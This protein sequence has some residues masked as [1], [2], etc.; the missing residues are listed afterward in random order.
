MVEHHKGKAVN[1]QQFV[2]CMEVI[3]G[4]SDNK[5]LHSQLVDNFSHINTKG[6]PTITFND[7]AN[8]LMELSNDVRTDKTSFSYKESTQQDTTI[9]YNYIERAYY[10]S[11]CDELYFHEQSM[12]IVRVYD[13][14]TLNKKHE[15][16]LG[17]PITCLEYI[18]G[19]DFI[20]VA[21]TNRDLMFI[22]TYNPSKIDSR[23][24]FKIRCPDS[25]LSMKYVP[26]HKRLFTGGLTGA[27]Y[28]WNMNLLDSK[29]YTIQE[30]TYTSFLAEG[31]PWIE[32]YEIS[33]I[34][35]IPNFDELLTGY[36]DGAI[37]C[38]SLKVT[39]NFII[40]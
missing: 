21:L 29:N 2:K 10:V 7:I 39:F 15:Y 17:N 31:F 1:L 8:Y 6:K 33:V 16:Y 13:P 3:L 12:K 24:E 28:G 35:D 11:N 9:H 36:S 20:T 32:K 26:R 23:K 4:V 22:E 34:T 5:E 38:W 18:E 14:L 25:T 37:R 30:L 40:G 19:Y 27:I